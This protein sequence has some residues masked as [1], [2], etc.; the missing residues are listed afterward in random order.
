MAEQLVVAAA[1]IRDG[2]VLAAQRAAP[3]ELAGRWAFPGG[4]VEA[5]ETP[6]AALTRECREELGVGL[7]AEAPI[8]GDVDLGGGRR[9]RLYRCTTDDDPSPIEHLALRWLSRHELATVRWLDSNRTLLPS[10]GR[11]LPGEG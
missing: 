4:K 5:G 2:R 8:A 7:I 10:V 11:L 1:V 6:E 9:L 3:A